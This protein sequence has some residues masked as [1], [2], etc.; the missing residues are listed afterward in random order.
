VRLNL[1]VAEQELQPPSP[2]SAQRVSEVLERL[3]NRLG[4]SR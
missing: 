3:Q 4:R 2:E 1:A